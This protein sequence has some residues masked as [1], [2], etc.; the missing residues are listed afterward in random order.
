MQQKK[1]KIITHK[2]DYEIGAHLPSHKKP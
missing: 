2:D 1:A